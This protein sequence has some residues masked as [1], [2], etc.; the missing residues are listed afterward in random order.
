[1]SDTTRATVEAAVNE[2]GYV[3]NRAALRLPRPA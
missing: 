2:L 1:M 3:P